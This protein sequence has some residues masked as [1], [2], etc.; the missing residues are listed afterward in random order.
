MLRYAN[1]FSK[2]RFKRVLNPSL[3]KSLRLEVEEELQPEVDS[4]K[5]LQV[6]EL[7]PLEEL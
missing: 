4:S 7:L 3:S 2:F 6:E 1:P 5:L